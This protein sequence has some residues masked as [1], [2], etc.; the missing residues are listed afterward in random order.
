MQR[1]ALDHAAQTSVVDI[2]CVE[3]DGITSRRDC[4]SSQNNNG[5]MAVDGDVDLSFRSQTISF[6][7][8]PDIA[9]PV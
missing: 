3:Y 1:N 4:S 6:E 5:G 8:G 2:L 7:M 9:A